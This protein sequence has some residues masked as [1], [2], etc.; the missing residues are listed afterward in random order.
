[1]KKIVKQLFFLTLLVALFASCKKDENK[2]YFQGGTSPVLTGSVASDT[3]PLS[4]INKDNEGLKLN[5]TNP[6]FQ[7]N[8]GISSQDVTYQI[9]IDTSGANF[10]NPNRQTISVSKDLSITFTQGQFNDYLLN[11]LQLKP[12]VSHNIE[13]RVT[14]SLASKSTAIISNVLKYAVIPFAIP[15][16][17]TPPASQTLYIVGDA[18]P[19]GW[20]PLSNNPSIEKFTTVSP[21]DYVITIPLNG[22][23]TYKFVEIVGQWAQQWSVQTEQPSGDPSTLNADLYFNG[24][25]CRAP[26]ASGTYKIDVDF[27]RGKI[28]LTKQ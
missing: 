1:M 3:L 24:A 20:P 27:Q 16:K 7:F 15:P 6:N 19:G 5:W 28:T 11:Q 22:D 4:Y 13:I 26:I 17:V 25:N 21:T 10:T 9:E 12:S 23:G 18:T 14:A 8:T 2:V